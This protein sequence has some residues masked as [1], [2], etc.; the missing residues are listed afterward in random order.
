MAAYTR[1]VTK[2]VTGMP[3]SA[4]ESAFTYVPTVE[5]PNHIKLHNSQYNTP[6]RLVASVTA[7][8][9]GGNT[10]ALST[11]HGKV[12]QVIHI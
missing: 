3:G 11:K 6:H 4:A 5:G 2:D 8:D 9:K 7:H 12:E 10:T 1:S